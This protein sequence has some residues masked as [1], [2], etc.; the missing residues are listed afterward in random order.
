MDDGDDR[1]AELA[2][3]FTDSMTGLEDWTFPVNHVS[4]DGDEVVVKIRQVLSGAK[5][6]GSP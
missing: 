1:Q 3:F 4:V 2:A 6:S 5:R